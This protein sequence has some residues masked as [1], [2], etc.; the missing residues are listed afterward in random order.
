MDAVR[1]GLGAGSLVAVVGGSGLGKSLLLQL[2]KR[3]Y[4]QAGQHAVLLPGE[5]AVSTG[6][7]EIVLVDDADRVPANLLHELARRA[8]RCVLAGSGDLLA[9]LGHLSGNPVVV[10]MQPLSLGDIGPY[11][12][13]QVE[14]AGWPSDLLT[15]GAVASLARHSAGNPHML[16]SLACRT[17]LMARLQD[18]DQVSERHVHLAAAHYSDANAG[19][20]F[21]MDAPLWDTRERS[22]GGVAPD[23]RHSPVSQP[24]AG[25]P[26]AAGEDAAGEDAASAGPFAA[27]T[28]WRGASRGV[29]PQT[30]V[31]A[32]L[33]GCLVLAGAVLVSR[34]GQPSVT[35]MAPPGDV[36]A[37]AG[38]VTIVAV[39]SPDTGPPTSETALGAVPA[40]QEADRNA[41]APP[42]LDTAQDAVAG[43]G[44][45]TP[46]TTLP[47][48]AELRGPDMAEAVPTPEVAPAADEPGKV[49]GYPAVPGLSEAAPSG[50]GQPPASVPPGTQLADAGK[51]N[52]ARAAAL[53]PLVPTPA[54]SPSM[55][56]PAAL[57][58][59]AS[60]PLHII[61]SVGRRD[62]AA[63]SR[64]AVLIGALEADGMSATLVQGKLALSEPGVAY[65]YPSDQ[66][67][68]ARVA[69]RVGEAG[70]ERLVTMR[71]APPRPG[72]IQVSVPSDRAEARRVH[73]N[74]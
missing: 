11:L 39:P 66:A 64:G 59:P 35:G 65:F 16:Q 17:L 31:A 21:D 20:A 37:S 56:T 46:A 53:S 27:A 7:T 58:R 69:R 28:G 55:A 22:S 60:V 1:A 34:N 13:E 45:A 23:V 54:V 4:L 48:N 52:D 33:I 38:P 74:P 30:L 50:P 8:P 49:P 24:A 72:T 19:S 32:G 61:V 25:Q 43:D 51:G 2:L 26:D 68:A 36:L 6:R 47:L 9:A 62:P 44:R 63:E 10:E 40:P 29:R 5:A 12:Q 18:A 42:A 3:E 15:P 14:R 41:G 57:S 73:D 70:H 71:G 67:A